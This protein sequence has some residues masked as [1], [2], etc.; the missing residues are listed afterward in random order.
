MRSYLLLAYIKYQTK[1]A[2]SML[3][4]SRV[5]RETLMARKSLID[6][7][8]LKSDK[9]RSGDCEPVQAVLF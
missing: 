4:L 9:L 3:A 5:I 8:S 7:L 1:Y 2:H 6:I